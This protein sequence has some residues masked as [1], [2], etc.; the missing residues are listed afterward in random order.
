MEV[1]VSLVDIIEKL[2]AYMIITVMLGELINF[3][4]FQTNAIQKKQDTL[5]IRKEN[6]QEFIIT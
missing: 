1:F 3:V 5:E 2:H 6:I 4:M